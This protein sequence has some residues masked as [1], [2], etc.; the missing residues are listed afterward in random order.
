MKF[1]CLLSEGFE[2]IEAI[3]TADLL[4]RAGITVDYIS[5]FNTPTVKGSYGTEV[6][7]GKMMYQVDVKDYDGIIVPGGKHAYVIRETDTVLEMVKQFYNNDKWMMSLCAGP[8]VF[9][10]VGILNNKKYI[11]FPGTENDMLDAIRVDA[12][13]VKDGKF[14]TARA[15]GAMYDFAF[16]IIRTVLG[17]EAVV[18]VKKRIVYKK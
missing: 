15:A 6:V 9:G 3:G 4:R 16:E 7:V 14:I 1:A 17:D 5:I 2:D 13:V 18:N 12:Q 10:A 8:T 11:S